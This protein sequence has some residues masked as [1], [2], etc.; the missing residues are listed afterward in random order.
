MGDM[1][2]YDAEADDKTRR[3]QRQVETLTQELEKEKKDN[4]WAQENPWKGFSFKCF[5][6]LIELLQKLMSFFFVKLNVSAQTHA[7]I[8]DRSCI[9]GAV[10]LAS[11]ALAI[12]MPFLMML[13]VRDF[14]DFTSY[15]HYSLSALER[16]AKLLSQ[17]PCNQAHSSFS[18]GKLGYHGPYPEAVVAAAGRHVVQGFFEKVL[19]QEDA[20]SFCEIFLEIVQQ[21]R[22]VDSSVPTLQLHGTRTCASCSVSG[23]SPQAILG[24]AFADAFG[25]MI[26]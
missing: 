16:I 17:L 26:S 2:Q 20:L 19:S 15:H 24:C 9:G 6:V 22:A 1:L 14:R 8:D 21:Q 5:T 3:L 11:I 23:R 4:A 18:A 10:L 25:F 12:G 13:F 7:F